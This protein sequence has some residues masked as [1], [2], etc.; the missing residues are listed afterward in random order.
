MVNFPRWHYLTLCQY[1]RKPVSVLAQTCSNID[2]NL[3]QYWRKSVSVPTLKA[4]IR[5]QQQKSTLSTFLFYAFFAQCCFLRI[6]CTYSWFFITKD[7]TL[8]AT[9]RG[10]TGTTAVVDKSDDLPQPRVPKGRQPLWNLLGRRTPQD[11]ADAY[12][13]TW[14]DTWSHGQLVQTL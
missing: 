6:F 1:W 10:R 11:C 7:G 12:W 4:I 2:A 3:F 8:S 9:S 5:K 13:F 14:R